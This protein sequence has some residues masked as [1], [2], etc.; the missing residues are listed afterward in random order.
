MGITEQLFGVQGT[1]EATPVAPSN[2]KPAPNTQVEGAEKVTPTPEQGAVEEP[3]FYTAEDLADITDYRNIEADRVPPELRALANALIKAGKNMEADYTRKT[4]EAA[5][6]K[7]PQKERTWEDEFEEDPENAIRLFSVQLSNQKKEVKRLRAIGEEDAANNLQDQLDQWQDY[8][9]SLLAKQLGSIKKETKREKQ[10]RE[11]R[12]ALPE[13]DKKRLAA[14]SFLRNE[15]Y[16]KDSEIEDILKDVS[17]VKHFSGLQEKSKA[18]E[19]AKNKEKKEAPASLGRPG[20]QMPTKPAEE[21]DYKKEFQK[22]KETGNWER[23]LLYKGAIK[24]K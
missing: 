3:Q 22:A 2:Y 16:K 18:A 13:F 23:I 8:K 20:S 9:D 6:A 11:M 15:M 1:E 17:M 12:D 7:K 4:M 19:T 21:F 24:E 5:D 14:T 10:L